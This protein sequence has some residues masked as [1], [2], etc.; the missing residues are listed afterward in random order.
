MKARTLKAAL[1]R[2]LHIDN[3]GFIEESL[4]IDPL[5]MGLVFEKGAYY[6][7]L[8]EW[9]YYMRKPAHNYLELALLYTKAGM[10]W[11]ALE[12]LANCPEKTPMIYY[13]QGYIFEETGNKTKA[14]ESYKTA[15]SC[16]YAYCFPN[17]TEEIL[18][19][20][21]AIR[22]LGRAPFAHYYLGCLL[23]DKK[24][25]K[26]AVAHWL[27]SADENPDFAL[28]HRNLAIAYYNK[29]KAIDKALIFMEQAWNL[30]QADSRL[31]M[32]YDQLC[33]KAGHSIETRLALLEK[34]LDLVTNRDALYV[35]YITL[36]NN[37]KQ[38]DRAL[39]C[40]SSHQFHPWEGGE[41]K[42]STQYRYALCERATLLIQDG[43]Y[44]EAIE[45]LN[46]SKIYPHS[47]G[48]GKLPNVQDNI[49][50]YYLGLAYEGKG[51]NDFAKES[52]EKASK[53]DITPGSVLYYN[54]QPSDTIFYIGLAFEK[55]GLKEKAR[56]CYEQLKSFGEEHI[57]DIVDYDYFA[58]SL[59]EIEVFP[60]SIQVR[61]DTYCLYLKGLGLLGLGEKEKAKKVLSDLLSHTPDYQGALRHI[62]MT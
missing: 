44:D 41:G 19:L 37:T 4:K 32:E 1:L 5:Y 14:R 49:A 53:G 59:P 52:F 55:L 56:E 35:E 3:I 51:E 8:D 30:D 29:E 27:T 28:V 18:I 38:F 54:D 62:S 20:E 11:E 33:S 22:L 58:V 23:Y 17:R 2:L 42:V 39:E 7:N 10:Y 6:H 34:H 43:N 15:E 50:D 47:L 12:I 60:T 57:K 9:K 16:D 31:L 13:Y 36:L 25:K 21:S 40:I 46:S 61:N 24:E 45:L 26:K 48:E